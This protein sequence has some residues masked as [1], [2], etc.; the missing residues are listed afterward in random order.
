MGRGLN[1]TLMVI[2]STVFKEYLL[3]LRYL[4][5]SENINVLKIN[6][7]FHSHSGQTSY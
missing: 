1:I 4:F 3:L 6:F 5:T 2:L 7:Y